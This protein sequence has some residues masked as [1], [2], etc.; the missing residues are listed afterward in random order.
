MTGALVPPMAR[1]T[2][3]NLFFATAAI[4]VLY[5]AH[6]FFGNEPE[7]IEVSIKLVDT[8]TGQTTPA[9]V[10]IVSLPD[11]EL[12]LPPDGRVYSGPGSTT[13]EFYK[14]FAFSA[15]RDWIGPVRKMA[16]YGNNRDRS[17]VYETQLSV[18]YWDQPFA[19]LTSGN[20]SIR[21][22]PGR[23]QIS[24]S[25]GNETIPVEE[26]IEIRGD[27]PSVDKIFHL[28]RWIDLPKEGWYS[29]D[30]H[31]HHPTSR[32]EFREFLLHYGMGEDLHVTNVLAMGH[33]SGV[34][35]DQAGFGKEYRVQRGDYW[36]VSGQEDPRSYFGHII[37]LNLRNMVR[38]VERYDLYDTAFRGI[39]AQDGLVGFAHFSWN[40]GGITRGFP[41][42]VATGLIDFVELLQFRHLNAL[43]YYDY[44]NLGFKLTAAAGSDVPWGSTV[45]EVRTYCYTGPELDLD[46]WFGALKAGH[47]FVSNGPAL[48]FT[49]DSKLPGSELHLSQG[50]E[51]TIK[52]GVRSHPKIGNPRYLRLMGSD[53]LIAEFL[54]T[55]K[56]STISGSMKHRVEHSQW[57]TAS[58]VCDNG[59]VA[60]SS[61]V[62]L[63]VD[64]QPFQHRARVP[65]LADRQLVLIEDVAAETEAWPD[66]ARK[67]GI[68]ERLDQ[69]REFYSGLK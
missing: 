40:G 37:G 20:F 23:Y 3:S 67:A 6:P 45:G 46:R 7:P 61:P 32:H 14:G 33:H 15:R 48:S 68:L 29:G 1:S 43:D 31:V 39:R 69:A 55:A 21:L 18:P 34:E 50:D 51:V 10:A 30:V 64:D 59:A 54:P 42:L 13:R 36:L 52:V 44:L 63:V 17:Y 58:T 4:F 2:R 9:M 56:S 8:Q 12:R 11:N 22:E 35:F 65:E 19:Y 49:V 27:K 25:R 47:T 57:I 66:D 5:L 38:D 41:W 26:E 62:Y 24:V 53:G 28:K 60:H 16:G